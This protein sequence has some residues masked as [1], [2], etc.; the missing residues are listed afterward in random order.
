MGAEAFL[1]EQV[2]G[3]S[4]SIDDR[5][6]ALLQAGTGIT[7]T[8]NDAAGTLTIAASSSFDGS[9]SALTGKPTTL[10]GYGITDAQPLD[11]DLTA[12]AALS[13]TAFG[14]ALLTQAD[15]AATRAT[16]GAGTSSFDGTFAALTG[17]PTTISG[18]G[19]T[20]A[21]PLDSDLTAIAAL[22]TTSFGRSLLTQADAAA[23]RSTIGAGTGTIGGSTGSTDNAVLRADGT[24]GATLQSSAFVIADISA[25]SPNNT[26]NHASIQAIGAT[27]NVSASVVPKGSGA[28]CLAVPDG[29]T[30][31][32]NA[33]GAN[34]VDLQTFRSAASNVASGDQ[35][36]I[37]GGRDNTAS[38]A[39][40]VIG[41]GYGNTASSQCS[42][43]VGGFGC[44]SSGFASQ[45]G[46]D[47][48]TASADVSIAD[49]RQAVA[50]RYGQYAHSTWRFAANG[51]MQYGRFIVA[52][53]TTN[54]TPTTLFLRF[55]NSTRLSVSTGE[56]LSFVANIVGSKSDGTAI[57][58]YMRRGVVK[59]ISNTTSLVG[60]I[61][62]IGTDIED[63]AS[64]DVAI[65][66]DD[67]NDALQINVTGIA[68]ETW[69]WVAVIDVADL[70]FGT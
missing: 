14:R 57:A 65:T 16:I 45:S 33:R 60:T 53:R 39:Q 26:V 44:S 11:S 49:G 27:T 61:Q 52:N 41:G 19:I 15:A 63:N 67:T 50:N 47:S 18:Y 8:Y 6:A 2:I 20:D 17:K 12:I 22:T 56:I 1:S 3:L 46:G 5:V 70:G 32:G 64:T 48:C 9:F 43:V 10:S 69:R 37:G 40:S 29:T 34:A 4:E 59:R 66:A 38:G 55:D 62:T 31:G 7:L 35:S 54:A 23:T 13:T 36:S 42:I 24:G 51:D 30:T 58:A 21:Q 28:F 25:A 68:G